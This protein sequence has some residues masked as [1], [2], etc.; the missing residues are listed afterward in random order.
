[1]GGVH[2]RVF[3]GP[4]WFDRQCKDLRSRAIRAGERVNTDLERAS[5]IEASK[6]YRA[7]KQKK[8][9][10]YKIE[11][12]K[13]IKRA[14][15]ENKSDMWNTIN[16]FCKKSTRA[17]GPDSVQFLEYFI[18]LSRP[19][20]TDYF[21][22]SYEDEAVLFLS[23]YDTK[24]QNI[25]SESNIELAIINDSFKVA[26]IKSAIDYLKNNKA[27]G[28]DSIPGEIIKYC[29][30][31]LAP[32]LAEVF[33]YIIDKRDFPDVWAEGLRSAIFKAGQSNKVEN[34]RGITILPILEKIFEVCVYK[35]LGF[36]N[37]AFRKIDD[38]NGGFLQGRR[39]S[40]NLFILSGIIQRQLVLGKSVALCFVD[41]SKAF[42]LINRNILFYKI[43]KMGWYGKV[44]D[45]LRSL[46]RKTAFRVKHNGWSSF[47]INDT[48]GVNQGGVASGLLFRKYMS[49]LGDYM[50]NRAGVCIG[51]RIIMHLLWADDLVLIAD[52]VSGLQT[53]VDGLFD[54]CKKNLTIV[55]EAKTKCMSFGKIKDIEITFNGKRIE[56]V[57]T[58]KYLGNIFRTVSM[59]T[60]DIFKDTYQYLSCQGTKAIFSMTSK[61]KSIG[62]VT[63]KINMYLFESLVQPILLYGS[64]V[65]ATSKQARY[66]IDRVYLRYARCMLNVKA[67]T[68][69]VMVYGECG[70]IPPS[71]RSTVNVLCF[72]NRL[73]NMEEDTL[74]KQVYCELKRLHVNGFKTWIARVCEMARE[75]H[76]DVTTNVKE[77]KK[78]CKNIV[79]NKFKSTWK[80]SLFNDNET[81]VL[82]TYR[83]I[84]KD[85]IFEPYL[86]LVEDQKYRIAI[87]QI[88]TS[89]H[90]LAIERGRHERPKV[91]VEGRICSTCRVVED[92]MHFITA[93]INNRSERDHLY[94]KISNFNPQFLTLSN[95]DKFV[96][97]F[98]NSESR[99]LTWLGKF[100]FKS[101]K[102]RNMI[103]C[104]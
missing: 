39:T 81:T 100:I 46:Y 52:N 68:S 58:Y 50:N 5:A 92:E 82:R 28:I 59:H 56:Q 7:V 27:P 11:C 10:A 97:L 16:R 55:N 96:Y 74:V 41:F 87:S 94:R 99:I 49:D 63:P 26:E 1:M 83:T 6:T 62:G 24:Y 77:F 89:S 14:Y 93:C 61:V 12:R 73:H 35:R 48:L 20:V 32:P 54:F 43:I 30:D 44:I 98:G 78:S 15:H 45:T 60:Q 72:A 4:P 23:M 18:S 38:A 29:R 75:H 42:D 21:D 13:E 31:I 53:L 69:N 57:S 64:D 101:F 8:E 33:N 40:D 104:T 86:D 70:H 76:V 88:R 19:Q 79:F 90:T 3:E 65:W 17:N 102:K 47:L 71:A 91:P 34:Y 66:E 37:E 85:F 95:S 22:R 51:D 103:N 36:A 80:N 9:R 84:K 67:T 25:H 2:L